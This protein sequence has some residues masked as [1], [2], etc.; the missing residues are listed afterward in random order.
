MLNWIKSWWGISQVSR[1]MN[2]I[3]IRINELQ[4]VKYKSDKEIELHQEQ[5][6][7][8]Q[9]QFNSKLKET[10]ESL[11]KAVALN[12]KYEIELEAVHEELTTKNKIV[13]PGLIAAC[14]T[15]T[16]AQ[17]AQSSNYA[18]MQAMSGASKEL[19]L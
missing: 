15:L 6:N 3:Q 8:L 9:D 12:K 5:L 1:Q 10:K 2:Y 13:I 4:K 11:A 7:V 16:D 17:D 18:A 19:D 14:K